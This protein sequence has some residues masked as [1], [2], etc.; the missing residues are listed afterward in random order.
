MDLKRA[1]VL[2]VARH[3]KQ[4]EAVVEG[5]KRYTY[6]EYGHRLYALANFLQRSGLNKGD[7]LLIGMRNREEC[8]LA[9]LAAHVMGAIAVPYNPRSGKET[10]GYFLR[11]SG[12]AGAF[13][14]ERTAAPLQEVL[15]DYP[16]CRLLISADGK[17]PLSKGL[18]DVYDL[19]EC[20]QSE[21]GN[22][23]P[24]SMNGDDVG[25][26][27]YTSGSTGEPKG[28]PITHEM[29]IFRMLGVAINHGLK[30]EDDHRILGVLPLFHTIGFHHSLL[31]SIFYGGTYYPVR[32][33]RPGE[34]I[35]LI[36]RE[37]ITEIFGAP[38]HFH[39]LL[40]HPDFAPSRVASVKGALYA[41]APMTSDLVK[42]CAAQLTNNFT[43]I[44]GN[45]ETYDSGY[46]RQAGTK[47]QATRTGIWHNIRI[48]SKGGTVEDVVPPNTEGELIISMRSPES[49]AG[50]WNKPSETNKACIEGWFCT[51]D[52]ATCDP[53]GTW[54]VTGRIDDMII[55]GGENIHPPEVESVLLRHPD[56]IDAV[57]LGVPDERLGQVVKAFIVA[58][59]P[60]T[61]KD[62]DDFIIADGTLDRWKRPRAYEFRES[63]P[64]TPSGKAQ[65][66]LLRQEAQKEA[67]E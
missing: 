47:P 40:R 12:A 2:S 19:E 9:L 24:S 34:V 57:V 45:T 27:L 20:V 48:R 50:Y 7:R 8:C 32:D 51:G 31:T 66:F 13:F 42:A 59:K 4:R 37:K 23:P 56:V 25:L 58:K 29:S 41:G 39:D 38:T 49:F 17:M 53:D 5:N 46:Y 67:S 33:Y 16:Q 15:P 65:R 28:V 6:E 44:Y 21:E 54:Y 64:R 52:S 43:H 35:A 63:L 14:E 3:G 55:S 26:L 11:D 36:E 62:M 1:I 61:S 22:E 18:P 30:F 10:V 60:L